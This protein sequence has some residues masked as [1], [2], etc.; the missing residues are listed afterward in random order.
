[1]RLTRLHLAA[2]GVAVL[3]GGA[4]IVPAHAAN[5]GY[6]TYSEDDDD[7]VGN[8]LDTVVSETDLGLAV[9]RCVPGSASRKASIRYKDALGQPTFEL[10]HTV[11]WSWDCKKVTK[12]SHT[13]GP[14]IYQPQYSFAGYLQNTV[15]N[16][17]QPTG[18]ATVQGRFGICDDTVVTTCVLERDPT[19]TWKVDAQGHA[20]STITP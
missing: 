17:G 12:L 20:K 5:L 8:T 6:E 9:S 13:S 16:P 19:I 1:M 7:I 15:G 10:W 4:H 14:V 18:A 3:L 11:T 2:A